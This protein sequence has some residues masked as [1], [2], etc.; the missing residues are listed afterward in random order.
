MAFQ[1]QQLTGSPEFGAQIRGL[2]LDALS[3]PATRQDL[4][5]LWIKHGLL[6]FKDIDQST[7]MHL[8]L[9][10]VFGPLEKHPLKRSLEFGAPEVMTIEYEPDDGAIYEINGVPRGATLPWHTDLIYNCHINHGGVM[11]PVVLPASDGQTG[12]IDKAQSYA[13][14]PE[15]LKQR[16]ENLEVVYKMNFDQSQQKFGK[17]ESFI[18]I[19]DN[20]RWKKYNEHPEL[21]P[22][23]IHPM[24]F[25]HPETGMKLLNV[26]PWF[27]VSI[28]GME[29]NEGDDLLAEIV[30]YATDPNRAYYHNWAAGEM[31]AFENWRVLHASAG[32]DPTIVRRFERTTISGDYSLGR[33]EDPNEEIHPAQLISV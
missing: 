26:S 1:T 12:F 25:I 7:E 16:I 21:F 6:V 15:R 4:Y 17:P 32:V 2:E 24:I 9:S 23:V 29:D 18:L 3:D 20:P 13:A 11:R 5:D 19:R 27:A 28:S 31:L 14:L 8:R 22:R 33:L 10:K 30:T